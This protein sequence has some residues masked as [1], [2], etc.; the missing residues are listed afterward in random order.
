MGFKAKRPPAAHRDKLAEAYR[1]ITEVITETPAEAQACPTCNKLMPASPE[2]GDR[3]ARNDVLQAAADRVHKVMWWGTP[4][5][6]RPPADKGGLHQ[7]AKAAQ[8]SAGRTFAVVIGDTLRRKVEAALVDDPLSGLNGLAS[9][10][11]AGDL[12]VRFD[13]ENFDSC[14]N[15]GPAGLMGYHTWPNG[16]SFLGLA[17]GGDWEHPVFYV[18]YWDGRRLRAYVPTGG[19][20]WNTDTMQAYG[21]EPDADLANAKKRGLVPADAD[22]VWPEDFAFDSAA[23]RK[24][25]E[26]RLRPQEDATRG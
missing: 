3:R 26:A 2:D 22:E 19:N 16:L 1:L 20:P 15:F 10:V 14:G 18:V 7:P 9:K 25:M 4:D 23:I 21:N 12:K 24:D 11:P 8:A 13:Y 5:E 6:K 17:A